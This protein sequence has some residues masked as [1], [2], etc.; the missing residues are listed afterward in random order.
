MAKNKLKIIGISV[1]FVLACSFIICGIY[2]IYGIRNRNVEVYAAVISVEGEDRY[3]IEYEYTYKNVSYRV[4]VDSDELRSVGEWVQIY[5]RRENP[6]KIYEGGDYMGAGIYMIGGIAGLFWIAVG[7][8]GLI[9]MT[10]IT[11][12]MCRKEKV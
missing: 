6:E 5:I 4:F 3:M 2:T 9:A 11:I 8:V 10:T 1:G 12:K 7:T